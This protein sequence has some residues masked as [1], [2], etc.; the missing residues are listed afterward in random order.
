MSI[1][2]PREMQEQIGVVRNIH[3]EAL[4]GFERDSEQSVHATGRRNMRYGIIHGAF[5]HM[6]TAFADPYPVLKRLVAVRL[7]S[8]GLALPL[9][10]LTIYAT[11][12]IGI[13]LAW[14]GV[15]IAAQKVGAVVSNL[16]W[17]PLGNRLGTKRVI[18]SGLGL[19][20][21]GLLTILASTSIF[22]ISIAFLLAGGAMSAVI[23]GFN[24]YILELGT[25]DIRPLL[26][27]LE[28]T[29]LFPLYFMPLCGGWLAD[30]WGYRAIVLIGVAL[31]T[32]AL[33]GAATLCE[34]RR[35]DPACSPCPG[36][37]GV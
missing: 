10:F 28:G 34:P 20:A 23:V 15:F 17:M 27:A 24:G 8:G 9:P 32:M 35:G 11:R 3:S 33:L 21:A 1:A 26:F 25:P 16:A 31:V 18:L 22:S 7:L 4:H 30:V 36:R 14:V 19:A 29:L 5:F 13:S 37:D 12:E 2:V 6:A